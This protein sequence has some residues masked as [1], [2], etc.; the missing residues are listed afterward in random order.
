MLAPREIPQQIPAPSGQKLECKSP[1]VGANVWCKSQGVHRAKIDTC[2]TFI[3]LT[4][5]L[6][7]HFKNSSASL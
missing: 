1:R 2:I 4:F 7:L 6:I 5:K 3:T